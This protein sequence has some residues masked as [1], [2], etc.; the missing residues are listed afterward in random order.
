[1][2]E[3]EAMEVFDGLML[4]DGGLGLHVTS[5]WFSLALS[6]GDPNQ[7]RNTSWNGR[8]SKI[9]QM[10]Y[11]TYIMDCLE[12]LGIKF[13]EECPKASIC[14]SRGKPYLYCHIESFSSGFLLAQFSRWYRPVTDEVRETRW[15]ATNRKWYKILPDDVVLTPLTITV[16]FEGDGGTG[17]ISRPNVQLWLATNSFAREEVSKLSELLLPFGIHARVCKKLTKKQITWELAVCAV[18]DVN[19]FFDLTER[20]IHSCYRYKIRRAK[21]ASEHNTEVKIQAEFSSLR[22]KLVKR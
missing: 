6:A 20:Y 8:N 18:A 3:K 15:F 22:S 16:W 2:N 5:A 14:L 21:Y 1:M 7:W 11:L 12:P 10:Q 4:G 17:W 13:S 19:I 9:P